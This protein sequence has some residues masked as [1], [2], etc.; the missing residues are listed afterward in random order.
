MS[1]ELHLTL[2]ADGTVISETAWG[3]SSGGLSAYVDKTQ[4]PNKFRSKLLLNEPFLMFHI[5]ETLQQELQ[6]TT[7]LGG[8]IGGT[9]AGAPQWA[10]IHALGRSATNT[11]LYDRAKSSYSS[12]FRDITVRFN[13]VNSAAQGYDLVTGLGS[14]LTVNFG[15]SHSFPDFRSAGRFNYP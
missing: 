1:E 12:Y 13:Y 14:P 4:I 8:K 10:A 11:N 9:S 5:T 6:F 2:K 3:N 15:T 7:V